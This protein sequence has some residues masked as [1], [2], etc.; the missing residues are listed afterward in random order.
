MW[1]TF[2]SAFESS[3]VHWVNP[4]P[5]GN[6]RSPGNGGAAAILT[7]PVKYV[8]YWSHIKNTY[9]QSMS[10]NR[11]L[12]PVFPCSNS[13]YFPTHSMKW[14]LNMPFTSWW[15]MS[16]ARSWRMSARGKSSVNSYMGVM[17]AIVKFDIWW[18]LRQHCN[19]CPICPKEHQ[20]KTHQSGLE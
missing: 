4:R 8:L 3:P 6:L 12:V 14:S 7:A 13:R 18:H 15:R 11:S 1:H 5:S 10:T 9:R 2:I 20:L 16:G 19:R 17:V